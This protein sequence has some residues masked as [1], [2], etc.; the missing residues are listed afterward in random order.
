[1]TCYAN[2]RRGGGAARHGT[3][4]DGLRRSLIATVVWLMAALFVRDRGVD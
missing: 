3:A 2:L 4:P 1:M